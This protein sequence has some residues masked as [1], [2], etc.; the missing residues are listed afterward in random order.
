MQLFCYEGKIKIILRVYD[1]K[2]KKFD[3]RFLEETHLIVLVP[4]FFLRVISAKCMP[5]LAYACWMFVGHMGLIWM[6][7]NVHVLL[8]KMSFQVPNGG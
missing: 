6:F 2:N 7:F 4:M 8:T 3:I 5:A 1:L